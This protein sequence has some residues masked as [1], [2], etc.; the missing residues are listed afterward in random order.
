MKLK[1]K[2]VMKKQLSILLI[3]VMTFTGMTNS[4][5]LRAYASKNVKEISSVNLKETSVYLHLKSGKPD[6]YDFN[7]NKTVKSKVTAC[8]WFVDTVKGKPGAVTIDKGTGIVTA[9]EAGTAFIGCKVTLTNGTVLKPE[10]KVVVRNN[11]TDVKISN[12]PKNKTITA[13]KAKNFNRTILNTEGGTKKQTQGVTRW[14]ITKDTAGVGTASKAGIVY[15][16]KAGSFKIRAV[17]F[18][19][20]VKYSL[21]LQDK[22]ANA[23][24]ITASSKWQSIRVVSSD[25]KAVANTKEQLDKVLALDDFKEI[26]LSTKKSETIVIQEGNY[27]TKSLIVDVPNADVE[28]HGIFK[29]I[30]I[31]AIKDTTWIEYANGNIVYIKDIQSRLIIDS[32]AQIKQIIVDTPN[33]VLNLD[34][35]G[36]VDKISVLQPSTV[37]LSGSSAMVP[38]TVEAKAG[39]SKITSSVP[40]NLTLDA[41]TELILEQGAENSV[42][43]KSA[44]SIHVK[45]TNNTREA[46]IITTNKTGMETIEAGKSWTSNAETAFPVSSGGEGSSGSSDGTVSVTGIRISPST[47]VLPLSGSAISA[48]GSALSVLAAVITPENATNATVAWNSANPSVA[49]V[50]SDGAVTPVGLGTTQIIAEAGGIYATSVVAVVSGSA[51]SVSGSA[52]TIGKLSSVKD[53]IVEGLIEGASSYVG[54]HL[55]GWG[56]SQIDSGFADAKEDDIAEMKDQLSDIS[57]KLTDLEAKINDLNLQIQESEY[58]T[59]VSNLLD[60]I[61]KIKNYSDDLNK[62]L[63]K[64]SRTTLD[65][66]DIV[67]GILTNIY[68]ERNRIYEELTGSGGS[69]MTPLLNVYSSIVKKRHRFLSSKDSEQ[70]QS[71]Y[72]YYE[73]LQKMELELV[74]EYCHCRG[75]SA[76]EINELIN[77]YQKNIEKEKALMKSPVPENVLIDRDQ[78]IM[79]YTGY[80][81]R[82]FPYITKHR[83]Y[84]GPY[85]GDLNG[86]DIAIDNMCYKLNYDNWRLIK[87]DELASWVNAS[88]GHLYQYLHNSGWVQNSLKE[89]GEIVTIFR[90]KNWDGTYFP[91]QFYYVYDVSTGELSYYLEGRADERVVYSDSRYIIFSPDEITYDFYWVVCRS[92]IQTTDSDGTV[93]EEIENYFY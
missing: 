52:I 1:R 19:S 12:P 35:H 83:T 67:T 59:R 68:P 30:T 86:Q 90:A 50:D 60:Y 41:D 7:M 20:K 34:I 77:R 27:G 40:L 65:R 81:K 42:I 73:T 8:I 32:G 66:D 28:N 56:L 57:K 64:S 16:T 45:V 71:V 9:K 93:H 44:G 21:W 76:D 13:G 10:A 47:M 70:I 53:K 84:A 38:L 62:Y 79:V 88:G 89:N 58:N 85:H 36:K 63:A 39:G 6:T 92:M 72:D 87:E 29:D 43:D 78:N 24:Y 69:G 75:K 91:D 5:P 74:V 3:L 11:I 26:T 17:A 55:L 22:K 54:G 82:Q 2:K 31:N 23:G 46:V 15:P 25:G 14:E 80:Y 51:L 61:T 37:N 48:T 4:M 18:Q 33:A 49:T